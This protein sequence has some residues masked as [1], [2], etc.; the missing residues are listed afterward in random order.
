[1]VDKRFNK[2]AKVNV[3]YARVERDGTQIFLV[4][5]DVTEEVDII[6]G[7]EVNFL[8]WGSLKPWCL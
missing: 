4:R 5:R 6:P 8:A 7:E 2:Q 3:K 1:M